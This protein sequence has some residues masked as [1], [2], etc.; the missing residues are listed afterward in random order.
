MILVAISL[1]TQFAFAQC[2]PLPSGLVAWWPGD[3][4]AI[5]IVSPNAGTLHGGATF[6]NGEVGSAFS[7]NGIDAYVQF[8][9]SPALKSTSL[10]LEGWFAFTA[11]DNIYVLIG[12]PLGD[13]VADSF[14]VYYANGS[15][16]SGSTRP[17]QT[18]GLLAAPWVPQIGRW[19]HLAYTLD[20]SA[21]VESMYIDGKQVATRSGIVGTIA[22]DSHPV[23]IGAD[24][25]NGNY[26]YFF[27]G[28]ADEVSIYNRA[29]ASGEIAAIQAAGAAGKCRG[30]NP[31]GA[32]IALYPGVSISGAIGYTYGV[33]YST[34]AAN[35]NGWIGLTNVTLTQTNQLW[36]DSIPASKQQRFYRV[37]S[38][39]ISIP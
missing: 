39:P 5:D 33:Q 2:E 36:Y 11:I 37:L 13:T 22:Y 15:L 20:D 18:T 8:P 28:K 32:A 12:K 17:G 19:Y 16:N 14:A 10:T 25:D 1:P 35:L 38:G 26:T 24:N 7:F 34:N 4:N 30:A 31:P 23:L 27:P 9:D 3:G 6:T 29:L 21:K